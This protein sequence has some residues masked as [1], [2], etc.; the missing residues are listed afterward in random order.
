MLILCG[1]SFRRKTKGVLQGLTDSC[2]LIK[3]LRS[4]VK[5]TETS[6]TYCFPQQTAAW[7]SKIIRKK[8]TYCQHLVKSFAFFEEKLLKAEFSFNVKCLG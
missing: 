3:L 1:C 8:K 6:V 7:V 5:F 2:A 4:A